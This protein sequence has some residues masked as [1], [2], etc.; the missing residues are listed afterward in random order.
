MKSVL[1]LLLAFA[2]TLRLQAE[3]ISSIVQKS[4]AKV[5]IY[6]AKRLEYE[7]NEIIKILSEK[8]NAQALMVYDEDNFQKAK[9]YN[10]IVKDRDGAVVAKYSKKDFKRTAVI[11]SAS[12]YGE[13]DRFHLDCSI[14]RYP[15]TVELNY[16]IQTKIFLSL[17]YSFGENPETSVLSS[18]FKVVYPIDFHLRY[19]LNRPD[20]MI[21]DSAQT[22]G[23]TFLKFELADKFSGKPEAYEPESNVPRV[24]IVPKIFEYGGITGSFS[25]WKDY[26]LWINALWN[27]RDKLSKAATAEIDKLI[28]ANPD[29]TDLAEAIYAYTQKNTRYV[30]ISYGLGGLQTMSAEETTNLGYGDCKALSNFTGTAMRYA[31]IEAYPALI[32]GGRS[33][34]PIDPNRPINAFNHVILCLPGEQDTTWLECTSNT[35]P[36]GYLSDFTDDRY[37]LLL[38]PNGGDLVKTPTYPSNVNTAIRN[39]SIGLQSDGSAAIQLDCTYRNLAMGK[40]TFF[41]QKFS[42]EKP[43]KAVK[44]EVSLSS[45]DLNSYT[46]E[47]F[48]D[49]EPELTVN[50][51]ID[52]RNVGR[53][54][55]AKQLVKPFIM[56]IPV[57]ELKS[58]SARNNPV[59]FRHGFE[60]TDSITVVL[61][62]ET[63]IL[64]P[65]SEIDS[66]NAFGA[67]RIEAKMDSAKNELYIVRYIRVNSGEFPVDQYADLTEFFDLL[68]GSQEA[69]FILE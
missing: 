16:I 19:D 17:S 59:F 57:P 1:F 40:T 14:K 38:T 54:V 13:V 42:S 62:S 50:C 53:K 61:P 68:R 11:T 6:S 69:F 3:E 55:G 15:Y 47:V 43:I 44:Y 12:S 64:Q 33:P 48:K 30:D 34:E 52:A 31:G 25:S 39:T 24:T 9:T 2:S 63:T 66:T 23:F 18:T 32:Y 45:F 36:F 8:G 4:E 21:V 51:S 46:S 20:L 37:A 10:I 41:A 35:F 27:G 49:Q 26:G 56:D 7:G 58:D 5:T 22:N 29:K 67:L 28:A 60:Y 65:I